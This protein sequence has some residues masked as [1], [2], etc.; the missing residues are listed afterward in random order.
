MRARAEA[1]VQAGNGPPP[2]DAV[3]VDEA[4]DLNPSLLRLLFLLCVAP[5]RF[6]ITAD[7]N[8]SIYGAGFRWTDVHEQ[9]RFVGRTGVLRTNYR[10]TR[11]I[12]EAA[13][14]YLAVGALDP[15]EETDAYMHTDGP[16]PVMRAVATLEDEVALLARFLR[17]A[18]R[19]YQLSLGTCAILCP[20]YESGRALAMMLTKRGIETRFMR[21][22]EIDLAA[23]CVKVI[24]LQSAK[25]LEF[26]IFAIAGYSTLA[27]GPH[28][29][30]ESQAAREES[31]AL[32]RRQLFVGMTRAMRALMVLTPQANTSPIFSGFDPVYWNLA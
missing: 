17:E 26:P 27:H 7:A 31:D 2:Y 3:I 24:T 23:P 13:R 28:T 5:N 6:F 11:Q 9:L 21:G 18:T 14:S 4:Q 29:E 15:D 32:R 8:Q 12:G 10:T 19:H 1:V 25:G 30:Q 22:Q 20:S 16:P